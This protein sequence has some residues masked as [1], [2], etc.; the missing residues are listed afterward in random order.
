MSSTDACETDT[1]ETDASETD[2]SSFNFTVRH[3]LQ[4]A[5]VIG[6]FERKKGHLST[7]RSVVGEE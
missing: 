2:S 4:V 7:A 6:H 5:S 1:S 3:E